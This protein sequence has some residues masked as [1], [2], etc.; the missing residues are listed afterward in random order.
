MKALLDNLNV[1]KLMRACHVNW[2]GPLIV[3]LMAIAYKAVPSGDIERPK[4]SISV[5]GSVALESPQ[6]KK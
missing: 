2:R 6:P 4:L 3:G 1:Y 5:A